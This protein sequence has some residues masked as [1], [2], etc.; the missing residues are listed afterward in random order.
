MIGMLVRRLA[1]I[2]AVFVVSAIPAL[3]RE[4]IRSFVDNVVL[5]TSGTVD[6]T[7]T[8]V[9]NAE[10]DEIRHGIFR[11]IPTTLINPDNSRVHSDLKVLSVTRDGQ[12]EPFSVGARSTS[13]KRI[14][15]GNADV[16]LDYGPHTYVI[17]YT[18][19]RMG[20]SLPD[21]DELYWNA[22]GNYWA[23]PIISAVANITLPG[24]AQISDTSVYTGVPG[25]RE[26]AAT[27]VRNPNGSVTFRST[28]ELAPGEGMTVSLSFQKGLLVVP[29][30]I[31]AA[32]YWLS[33]HREL[34]F[35]TVA[36]LIVLLYNFLAWS[37]VGRDPRKGTIIPL[38]HP[39]KDLSPAM[40]HYIADMGFKKNGWTAFIASIFDLGVKG[41]AKI[42]KAGGQTNIT[43]TAAPRVD[44]LPTDE[45]G[46]YDYLYAKGQVTIDKVD[47]PRLNEKRGALVKQITDQNKDV[48]F[49][50]NV[51]YTLGGVLLAIVLLGALVWL[52]VLDPVIL[53]VAV[54]A[55]IIIGVFIGVAASSGTGRNLFGSAFGIIW[56]AIVAVNVFGSSLSFSALPHIDTG[57]IGAVSII[58]IEIVFAVL[59]RAPTVRG[60]ALMDQIAGFKMYLS[61]AEKNRL[62]YVDK[63]EPP[64]TV[65]RFEA[66][67]PFAIAL[68]V[69]KLWS[70]RFEG[71]LA[72][73]AV[74]G[75]SNGLYTP[76]WYTGSDWSSAS[77]GIASSI[78]TMSSAMSAAMV[79][80]QP[81]SSGSSGFGGGGGSGGGG[82]GG[83]G[84]G[85]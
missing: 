13:V 34:V 10:G 61:T 64:M 30:G 44:N 49:K 52:E 70:Q 6:V 32:G 46:V 3:A 58:L 45:Q 19:S 62:N 78:G 83:G 8:L 7:E 56:F 79:A 48:Y 16:L 55:A 81:S 28:R 11:D 53:I 67:L 31:D 37:A 15:I 9:V 50:N 1:L 24:G 47:G 73:N 20:R 23:F 85:W 38:F 39:P 82:G 65:P 76:L 77:G 5:S 22:T 29:Q 27:I 41:L 43:A 42:D 66:I 57:L 26:Q 63:G 69:E 4:E 51:P 71:D 59:M 21:H 36:V 75:V 14:Q 74:Q 80:A 84:G 40:V 25:S 12:P 33:D 2:L 68:G 72:R 17:H 60:R 35:P 18:M 54:V